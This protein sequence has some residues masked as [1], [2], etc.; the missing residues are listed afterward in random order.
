MLNDDDAYEGWNHYPEERRDFLDWL[1][2]TGIKVSCF[3]PAT[4]TSA[5]SCA[6]RFAHDDTGRELCLMNIQAE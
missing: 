3:S 1:Q 6:V 2:E 5:S 4:A